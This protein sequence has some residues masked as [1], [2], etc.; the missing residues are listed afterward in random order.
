KRRS[1][2]ANKP[3]KKM[4]EVA[5]KVAREKGLRLTKEQTQSF[6]GCRSW[7]DQN[8]SGKGGTKTNPPT[9]KMLGYARD[10]AERKGVALP[11]AAQTSFDAC[12]QF[13]NT[14][15]KG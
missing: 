4:L 1:R 13:L 8:L 14:H 10:L 15:A 5:R 12:K 3:T 7:L 2:G 6:D 11:D 9:E